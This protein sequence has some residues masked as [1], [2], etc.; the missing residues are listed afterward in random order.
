MES[1]T[2]TTD[3]AAAPAKIYQALT[4]AEGQRGW[5]TTDCEVGKKVGEEAAFRF[6]PMSGGG[7]TME[8]RFRIDT[9]VPNEAVEWTCVGQQNNPEWQGTRIAFRLRSAGNGKTTLDFA[10]SGFAARSAV[11][12][13]CT[14]GWTYFIESLKKYAETGTGTPHVR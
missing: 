5:W 2:T 4:T 1:I 6:N 3:I 12:E 10:H 14:K 7:G 11:Y 8:V 9:L 13:A